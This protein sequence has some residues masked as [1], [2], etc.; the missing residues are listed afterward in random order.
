MVTSRHIREI[1][2]ESGEVSEERVDSGV[3]GIL[4]GI[5]ISTNNLHLLENWYDSRRAELDSQRVCVY[6]YGTWDSETV[7]CPTCEE[8]DG[9]TDYKTA[10]A[11]GELSL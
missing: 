6:C 8:Y 2:I 1:L 4:M 10:M 3:I 5:L 9:M 11:E 7:V